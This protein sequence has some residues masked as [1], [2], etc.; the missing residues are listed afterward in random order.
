MPVP[1]S[2]T[3]RPDPAPIPRLQALVDPLNPRSWH[4]RLLWWAILDERYLVESRFSSS[5]RALLLAFDITQLRRPLSRWHVA[6][7]GDLLLGPD[8]DEV[9]EWKDLLESWADGRASAAAG[10]ERDP[11]VPGA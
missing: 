11:R 2:L 8:P 6:L 9:R 4:P 10:L 3:A 1:D 7:V 5:R